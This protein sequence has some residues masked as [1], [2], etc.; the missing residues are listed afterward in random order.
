MTTIINV[1]ETAPCVCPA[2]Y[3]PVC[4]SDV[5]IYTTAVEAA[6]IGVDILYDGNCEVSGCTADDGTFY[7]NGE[8]WNVD[9]C[10]FCSCEGGKY[11][12]LLLT[13]LGRIAKTLYT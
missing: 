13:V 8:N 5:V 6:C 4:A 9:D 11:S 12:V 2:L 10:S 3:A 1:V 7:A